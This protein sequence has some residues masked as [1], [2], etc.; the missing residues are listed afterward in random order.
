MP[1]NGLLTWHIAAMGAAW[2]RRGVANGQPIAVRSLPWI[3]AGHELHHLA[4]LRE[5]YGVG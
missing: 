1:K 2:L 3:L 4:V 5:R